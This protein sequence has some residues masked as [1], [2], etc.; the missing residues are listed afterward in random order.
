[1]IDL[2]GI[3]FGKLTVLHRV[4][5]D[6]HHQV[7]W[8]CQCDCGKVHTVRRAH[9]KSKSV[10]SCGCSKSDKNR[11]SK[12]WRGYEDIPL[13]FWNGYK[14]TAVSKGRTFEVSIE[15]GW[16]LFLRQ[17]Q[18]CA[19]SGIPLT[20]PKNKKDVAGTASLDRIDSSKGYTTDN[21]QWV[22]KDINR[23]KNVFDQEHFIAFCKL[24]TEY[25]KE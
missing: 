2:T 12:R 25:N 1:M 14:R 21:V 8:S 18:Q 24:V 7:R 15:Q 9:L 16:E 20:F 22:H 10:V 4:E 3:R 17:N 6:Q 5:N 13:D 23:M 11:V 19:L